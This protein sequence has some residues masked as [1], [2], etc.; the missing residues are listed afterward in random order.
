MSSLAT[1]SC[2]PLG[3]RWILF[4]KWADFMTPTDTTRALCI[5]DPESPRIV[6]DKDC[7]GCPFWEPAARES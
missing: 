1:T 7:Y 5:R 3:C 4:R 6:S 2:P